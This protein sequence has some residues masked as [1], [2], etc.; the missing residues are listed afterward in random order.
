MKRL[1]GVSD[2]PES[3]YP[4]LVLASQL[5]PPSPLSGSDYERWCWADPANLSDVARNQLHYQ[6]DPYRNWTEIFRQEGYT[7]EREQIYF[8]KACD[9]D[10]EDCLAP[11]VPWQARH[12]T[13]TDWLSAWAV[14][15]QKAAQST[16]PV[17][18]RA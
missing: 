6:H 16:G 1:F 10:I 11:K 12:P 2:L 3:R 7:R 14:E 5:S 4:D 18:Y 9:P 8:N 15:R 13:R 17:R